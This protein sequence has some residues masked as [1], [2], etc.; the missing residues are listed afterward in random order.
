MCGA[1]QVEKNKWTLSSPPE[2]PRHNPP[3]G[4]VLGRAGWA[5][6]AFPTLQP[7]AAPGLQ[8]TPQGQ[9]L[10]TPMWLLGTDS[11]ET[12]SCHGGPGRGTPAQAALLGLG[13][14]KALSASPAPKR[15]PSAEP[16]E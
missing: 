6:E 8:L 9:G 12:G 5:W 10:I 14:L 3:Q 16:G 1:G 15:P 4:C 2:S 11:L 13:A 7:L